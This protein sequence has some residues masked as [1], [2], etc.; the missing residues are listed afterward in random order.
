[1]SIA[2]QDRSVVVI[3]LMLSVAID[4]R[5]SRLISSGA[6]GKSCLIADAAYKVWMDGSLAGTY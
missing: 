1:V 2:E 3:C 4:P 5:G 6:S